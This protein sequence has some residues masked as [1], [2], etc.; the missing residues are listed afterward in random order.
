MLVYSHAKKESI[1]RAIAKS[2]TLKPRIRVLSY[3]KFE[4]E[5]TNS[6]KYTVTFS[7]NSSRELLINCSCV[8]GKANLLC[9]H[10]CSAS[11]IY[12]LNVREKVAA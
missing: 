4:V 9:Y 5:G 6:T 8:A 10:A 1:E 12:K 11:T 7:F 2:K 3:S